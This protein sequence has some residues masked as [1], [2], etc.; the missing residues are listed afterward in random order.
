[1]SDQQEQIKGRLFLYGALEP[2]DEL[3][4]VRRWLH[5]EFND[6]SVTPLLLQRLEKC[7][8]DMVSAV[9]HLREVEAYNQL[10]D[11]VLVNF[12]VMRAI[13]VCVFVCCR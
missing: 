4:E 5:C 13:C 8:K 10:N 9:G 2:R 3:D 11:K 12:L 1:M 6:P 7:H